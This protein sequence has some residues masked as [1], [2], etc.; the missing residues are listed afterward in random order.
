M[1]T[2]H[3]AFAALSAVFILSSCSTDFDIIGPYEDH[4]V[5]F[6][7]LDQNDTIHFLKINKAFL[8]DGNAF[9]Y[10]AVQDSSEYVNISGVVEAWENGLL[11]ASYP[12][13]DTLMQ[14]RD[15]GIFY[16]PEQTLYYFTGEL[17]QNR[18]YR[19]VLNI[20]DGSKEVTASTELVHSFT[21][22]ALT[23]NPFYPFSLAY[24]TSSVTGVYPPYHVRFTPGVNGKRYDTWLHFYYDEYTSSGTERKNLIWKIDSYVCATDFGTGE[25]ERDIVFN[26]DAF[27]RY[28][29]A[30]LDP[31]PNVIKRVPR[32]ID[33]EIVAASDDLYTY[34]KVNEPSTGLVQE[35]PAFTNLSNAIGIFAS[36]FTKT[37]RGKVLNKDSVRELCMGQFTL[38][39]QF[40]T[41]SLPWGAEP[42]FCP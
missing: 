3:K 16:F 2:F 12:I 30:R 36:R 13:Y 26:G 34:M 32:Q 28:V 9:D 8:G 22:N 33:I 19:L 5:V 14:N 11:A 29:A 37:I 24:P 40:C 1:K 4:T 6:G 31:D 7:L 15:T 41:D 27:Y 35:R 23:S 10:A 20:N 38:D 25:P 17:N 18:E 21:V 39:L 42:Y